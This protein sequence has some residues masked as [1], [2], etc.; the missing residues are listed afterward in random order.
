MT[1]GQYLLLKAIK[2]HIYRNEK[3]S[4][5]DTLSVLMESYET[6]PK[7]PTCEMTLEGL[8]DFL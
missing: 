3:S 6:K 5:L 2:G 4:A 7:C 1:K 8:R